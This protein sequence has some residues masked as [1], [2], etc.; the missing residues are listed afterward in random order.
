M[1]NSDKEFWNNFYQ[2]DSA[3]NNPSP[4][5]QFCLDQYILPQSDLLELGSGNGRDAFFFAQNNCRVLGIDQSEVAINKNTQRAN[6]LYQDERL[7]FMCDD[8]TTLS[9][10][11]NRKFDFI[12]SRFTMHSVNEE[13]QWVMLGR[14]KQLLKKDGRLLIEVRTTKDPLFGQGEKVSEYEYR[15]DHYRRFIDTQVFLKDLMSNGWQVEYFIE[16]DNLAP[17]K[18]DNPIVS[19]FALIP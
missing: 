18:D 6:E 2:S 4:F 14:A 8:F 10:V 3:S 5:A 17:Y 12:Y 1:S 9:K 19:R 15:T 7:T 13:S 11:D 16:R